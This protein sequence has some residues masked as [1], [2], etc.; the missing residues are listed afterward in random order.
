[1]EIL[2]YALIGTEIAAFMS[3]IIKPIVDWNNTQ[4]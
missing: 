3:A 2:I 4:G 1:M